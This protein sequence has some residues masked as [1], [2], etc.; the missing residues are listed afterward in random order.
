M[1]TTFTRVPPADWPSLAGFIV[2]TNRRDGGGVRCLHADQGPDESAH[3]EELAALPPGE[4]AFWALR[5]DG[6]LA[7][8]IGCEYDLALHRAWVRGPLVDDPRHLATLQALAGPAL[9]AALPGIPHFDGFPNADDAEL[10]AWYASAGYVEKQLHRVLRAA[11][12]AMPQDPGPVR[13]ARVEDVA[14]AL[15]LHGSLFPTPYV[16]EADF[17]RALEAGDRALFVASIDGAVAAYLYVQDHPHEDEAYVDYLGVAPAHRGRGLARALLAASAGF[18]GKHGRGF[19]AL[20]VS[21]ERDAAKG[22]YAGAGFEELWA[23]RHW[24]K[25]V[26]PR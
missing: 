2:R 17:R 12:S 5:V 1:E 3:A 10:N 25:E 19:V 23:G 18:A 8:V 21:E 22:L 7:G 15:A 9:E 6:A 11:P 26:A 20:T 4:A 24:R 16:G 13:P 14:G